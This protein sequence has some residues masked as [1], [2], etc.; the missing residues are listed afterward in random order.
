MKSENSA[1]LSA[2]ATAYEVRQ[3]IRRGDWVKHTS[4]LASRN[5]QGNIAILPESLAMDFLR[6]CQR[7]PKP[8]PLLAVSEPGVPLLPTLGMMWTSAP[9]YRFTASG[10]MA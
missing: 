7:N 9:T 1:E 6:F 8:C 4:G 10:K 2:S 5:A 3:A